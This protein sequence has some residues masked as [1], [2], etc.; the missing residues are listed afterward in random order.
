[1][2]KPL[3]IAIKKSHIYDNDFPYSVQG[4]SRLKKL[5][6]DPTKKEFCGCFTPM[7][8][9]SLLRI[10]VIP[11]ESSKYVVKWAIDRKRHGECHPIWFYFHPSEEFLKLKEKLQNES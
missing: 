4:L 2:K 7:E 6:H 8:I 3:M 1:M 5:G 9:L 11:T 10:G